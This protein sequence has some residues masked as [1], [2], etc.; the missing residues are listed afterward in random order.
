MSRRFIFVRHGEATH[1]VAFRQTRDER[2]FEDPAHEDAPL[3]EEGVRQARQ[4]GIRL[5]SYKI[6]DIWC[7]PLTRCIQTALEIFEETSAQTMTFH[8]SLLERLGGGHICNQRKPRSL[9]DQ[10]YPFADTLFLAETPAQ[11]TVRE[12][13]YALRQR[14]LSMILT[15]NE[16]YKND[17]GFDIVIVSH[18]DAI[19]ALIEK[20]LANAEFVVLTL[21]EILHP[22]ESHQSSIDQPRSNLA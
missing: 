12:N 17:G 18:A 4:T 7:S 1:N 9:L 11:W 6:R 2:V 14:M 3:T 13:S 10:L 21:D 20:S 8:D 5:S 22:K 19:D 16:F 15:L